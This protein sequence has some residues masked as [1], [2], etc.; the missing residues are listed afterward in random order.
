MSKGHLALGSGSVTDKI[1][2]FKAEADEAM[3]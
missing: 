2:C 1:Y 3:C